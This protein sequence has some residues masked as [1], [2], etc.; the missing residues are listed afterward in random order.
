MKIGESLTSRVTS[1]S[2]SQSHY[3]NCLTFT[4]GGKGTISE[5]NL[6]WYKIVID[7]KQLNSSTDVYSKFNNLFPVGGKILAVSFGL[8]FNTFYRWYFSFSFNPSNNDGIKAEHIFFSSSSTQVDAPDSGFRT[9]STTVTSDASTSEY[10][11]FNSSTLIMTYHDFYN[12]NASSSLVTQAVQ[13]YSNHRL[14]EF[15][16]MWY[17]K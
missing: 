11:S 9:M 14:C 2:Q 8:V 10:F 13:N 5:S 12:P 15:N 1:V 16:C 4:H 6:G 7:L 17:V 3:P